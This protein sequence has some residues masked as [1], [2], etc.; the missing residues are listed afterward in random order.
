MTRCPAC[1]TEIRLPRDE[2]MP[3]PGAEYRCHV[4]RLD[5]RFDGVTLKMILAPF[6]RDHPVETSKPRSRKMPMLVNP[7]QPKR[8]H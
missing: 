4:C 1:R 2:S 3:A 6:E 5:L 8:R 7:F